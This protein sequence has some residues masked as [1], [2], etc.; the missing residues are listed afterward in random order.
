MRHPSSRLHPA[1]GWLAL[2]T[3]GF[4]LPVRAGHAQTRAAARAPRVVR[5]E[6]HDFAFVMPDTIPAGTTTFRLRNAGTQPHHLMLYR[7][8]PGRTLTDVL[9]ALRAGGAHPGWMHPVGGPNAIPPGGESVGTVT[10]TPGS[11]VA[12]CHIPS[13][14]RVIHFAKGMLKA[15]TV[16]P[17]RE[18]PAPLPAA[19]VT[20]TLRDYDFVFSR[21]LTH[22][23][24]RVAVTNRGT[25][26]HELIL[27][28]LDPGRTSRDFVR[29]MET[30][31]GRPPV[32]PAGGTTD[33]PPEGT[34]ILDVDLPPGRYSVLCRVRDTGDGRPHDRHGML[35]EIVVR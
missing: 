24:H 17:G 28:R 22:G 25:Q 19:D 21:P 11:Y 26:A 3:L 14:D 2:A 27:S 16:V 15:V 12:F 29:W 33:L 18:P 7:L 23:R 6:A 5:V 13:P 34:I 9:A 31:Q 1:L 30:Q 4:A 20:V 10:L 8:D 32:T 35:T